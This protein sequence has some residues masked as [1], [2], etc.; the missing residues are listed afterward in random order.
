MTPKLSLA[1]LLSVLQY[2]S[3]AQSQD[4]DKTISVDNRERQFLIHLPPS[5]KTKK[6]LPV[7]FAFHGG[8]GEYKK[9]IRYYN[10]TGLADENGYIVVY[11]NAINKAWSMHGVSSRVKNIDNNV[12]DVKFIST[13][14][15][16]LIANYKAD[17]K[18][19]FCTGISRGGIFSLF[20]AWQLSDRI[21]A[22]APVCA[23][24]PQAISTM[25]SF[26]HPTP[27]LL[28]NGTEDP[29]ISY[30][31]GA[32]KFNGRNEGSETANMMPTEELISKIKQLNNCTSNAVVTNLPDNDQHDGCTAT[33][34][35][36]SCNN[37]SVEL[38]KVIHGGH[39]WPGGFQ[40]LPKMIIGKTCKDFNAEEKIF[41]FF[42][43]IK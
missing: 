37:A 34:Y 29:L 39:T 12:D 43:K 42:K 4:I 26:K 41:E 3:F 24:I 15:D 25:Y 32:G 17:N 31:G 8:G 16:Y 28:I 11:P 36:Y 7:I 14:L 22:I 38:L 13:L 23:S 19:V 33:S 35:Y 40:Y 20:L 9:T 18:H 2:F 6:S 21:T 30:N 1:F 5:F 10:L 27:V